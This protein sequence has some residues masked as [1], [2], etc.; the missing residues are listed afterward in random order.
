MMEMLDLAKRLAAESAGIALARLGLTTSRR[1]ADNSF[2]TEADHAIQ[3]HILRQIAEAFPEHAIRAEEEDPTSKDRPA[4]PEARYCWV[5]D[6][7]DGT[8]NYVASFPCFST[9]IAV[10]DR[11][12]PLIG[13]VYGHDLNMLFV[14]TQGGGTTLNGTSVRTMSLPADWD[15]MIGIPSSKDRLT[16]KVVCRWIVTR[17]MICRN[18]GSTALHLSLV[19]S[20]GLTA[21]FCQRCKLWDVAAGALLVTEAGGRVTD[22]G[23]VDR[24]VF[25]LSQPSHADVPLL[26]SSPDVHD[27]ILATIRG[28]MT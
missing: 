7:L 5:I 15:L 11:G 1:K 17:G 20:G 19:A 8:R 22:L 18:L 6:P 14:A 21:A 13:V 3:V 27:R 9:S 12:R 24:D 16:A 2:V 28:A 23:G 10:L 25:D 4:P 26:A